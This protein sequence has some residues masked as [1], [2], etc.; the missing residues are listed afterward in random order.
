LDELVNLLVQDGM[1]IEHP[2]GGHVPRP[3]PPLV[4]LA[5][6]QPPPTYTPLCWARRGVCTTPG[7]GRGART[8][9]GGGNRSI[10]SWPIWHATTR[11]QGPRWSTP[12]PPDRGSTTGRPRNARP[13]R[14]GI[15]MCS[16]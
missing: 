15:R 13:L 16:G 9:G 5:R 10:P 14:P 11:P 2:N 4:E 12:R 6:C 7:N 1:L 8:P 3:P